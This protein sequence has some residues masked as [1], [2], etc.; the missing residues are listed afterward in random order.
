LSFRKIFVLGAGAIGSSLAAL[1]SRKN[2]V[3]LI[4]NKAHVDAVNSNRLILE[5]DFAGRFSL[6]AETSIKEISPNSLILLT[7]KAYDLTRTIADLKHI[8]KDDTVILVLQ[9]GIQIKELA[10]ETAKNEI[11]VVRGLILMAAEFFEPGKIRLWNGEIIVERSEIGEKITELFHESEL[12]TRVSEY[13]LFEEWNKLVVNCVINPLTA[14]LRV[15]NNEIT[16]D[17]LKEIRHKIVEECVQVGKAEGIR[18]KP[19]LEREIN[20]KI[21]SYTNYSSMY[22]DIFKRKETEIDFLNGII[23]KLGKKH[24]IPTSANETMVGLI[25]FMEAQK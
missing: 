17:N 16:S 10:Q 14:I 6:K 13:I 8:L 21:L 9:N 11:Q 2:D 15:R 25:K 12:K 7:T 23:V 4:G 5:G 18:F 24:G 3:T 20:R 19:D 22:Q 1:L